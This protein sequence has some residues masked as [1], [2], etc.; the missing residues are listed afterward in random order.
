M[1]KHDWY[2]RAAEDALKRV[3][4]FVL[5]ELNQEDY[6]QVI[7][8]A[9]SIMMIR[10][11][12]TRGGHFAESIVNNDLVGAFNTADSVCEKAIKFFVYVNQYVFLD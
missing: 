5:G 3:P 8:I 10:D 4:N 2:R 9:S 1:S 12:Q 7:S 11:G 6:L